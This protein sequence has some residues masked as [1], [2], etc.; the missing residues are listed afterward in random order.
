MSVL[1]KIRGNRDNLRIVSHISQKNKSCDPS[2][3]TSRGDGSDEGSKH[4]VFLGNTVR[5]IL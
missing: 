5:K 3:E 4:S 2:L 1:Q